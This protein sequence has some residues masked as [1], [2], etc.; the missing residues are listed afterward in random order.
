MLTIGLIMKK[1]VRFSLRWEKF[2]I[3]LC[4]AL[5]PNVLSA[6]SDA[7]QSDIMLSETTIREQRFNRTGYSIWQADSLPKAAVISLTNRL[8][9]EN[10]LTLRQ[11]APGT[12]ATIS[13]RGAGP[14]RT[15]VLWNGLNLQ[16]PM[17]GVVDASLLP[18]W[19]GDQVDVQQ[20]GNSAA[21]SSGAMGG[22]V[23]IESPFQNARHGFTGNLGLEGGSFGSKAGMGA[24]DYVSDEISSRLRVHWQSAENDFPFQKTGL[25]GKLDDTRQQNNFA[26]KTDVQQFN[27]W[28]INKKNGLKTAAWFQQSFRQIPPTATE[29]LQNTWQRDQ[30]GRAVATWDF[31]PGSRSTLQTRVAWQDEFITFHFAGS[32]EESRAQTSLL[33]TEWRGKSGSSMEWHVG[34]SAQHIRASSDG[35]KNGKSWYKQTRLAGYALGAKTFDRG[36]KISVQLRQEWAE[37]QA[38]P[39]TWTLGWEIPTGKLGRFRGHFSRNF[40]LPTFNDRFWKTLEQTEL[41]PEKGYSADL[42]WAVKKPHF[43]AALTAFQLILDDWILWQPGADGIFR[44]GN[45]RKVSSRG[46]EATGS[47]VYEFWGLRWKA[48]GRLQWSETENIAVYG[49]AQAVLGKQLP[50]SPK[51]LA[52]GGLWLERGAFSGAYLHQYTGSRF[53]TTDAYSYLPGNQTG[54]VL[55]HYVLEKCRFWR[56]SESVALDFTLDNIWNVT[57][58]SLA[59]RPMPGRNW[60]AG[61]VIG[62]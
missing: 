19:P 57:Y 36:A 52:G 42:G 3:F 21:Q 2:G 7:V 45:L 26:E 8:F 23:L 32:T 18:L 39:F 53:I 49:G 29:A 43:S 59:N 38:A 16:S 4:F 25:Y 60:R 34:G 35:Y 24:L 14:N 22:A 55:L 58:E 51:Y 15:A 50:Y 28:R 40:N 61:L 44:P 54:T 13:A 37:A 33:S 30:S 47:L 31:T 1:F 10:G 5:L 62:W 12:L 56:W 46:L 48:K 27:R 17:N 6:Q 9:W 11:N 20:G 41:S